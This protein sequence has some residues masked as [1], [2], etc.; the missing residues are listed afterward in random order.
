MTNSEDKE[1]LGREIIAMRVAKELPDG[2]YV[3]LGIG[4][5]TLVSSFVPEGNVVFY[6]SESGILNCG[7]LADEGE[8]DIDLINAG[9]Q[10]LKPVPGAAFFSSADAFAMIRGGH[11]DVTVLGS[12]QV[13]AKGDLA[14]WM[15]PAR[16]VGNVG[17]AMDLAAGAREVIVAMEHTDRQDRPKIV[18]ECTFPLTGKEC[19]SLIV[20]DLAVIQ[21][22]REGL[23]LKEVAPGWTPEE[24]QSL[25]GAELI[26]APDLKEYEL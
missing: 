22:T 15:L 6:H 8:E 17:G 1:R 9:G 13:S 24:V 26:M 16:G 25:T 5:P 12:H 4:I 3:N 21:C 14:N 10:F 2:A 7:P 23:V 18:E 20:T 11:V 19:V